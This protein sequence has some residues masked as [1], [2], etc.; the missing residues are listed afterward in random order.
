M[1]VA[2]VPQEVRRAPEGHCASDAN[3]GFALATYL[4]KQNIGAAIVTRYLYRF[5]RV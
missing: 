4:S 2:V 5:F 1:R 3:H